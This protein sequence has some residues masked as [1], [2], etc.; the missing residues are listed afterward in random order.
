MKALTSRSPGRS[1]KDQLRDRVTKMRAWLMMLTW[2]YTAAVSSSTLFLIDLTP[3]TSCRI[4]SWCFDSKDLSKNETVY[5]K[6]S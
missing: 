5:A 1:T 2:R 4:Q 3:N 6:I